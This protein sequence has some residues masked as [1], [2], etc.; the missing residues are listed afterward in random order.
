MIYPVKQKNISKS[1]ENVNKHS[2]LDS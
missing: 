1:F 2:V